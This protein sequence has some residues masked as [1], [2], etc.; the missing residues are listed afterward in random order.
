MSKVVLSLIQEFDLNSFR[1]FENVWIAITL[2]QVLYVLKHL[3]IIKRYYAAA[4]YDST[5]MNIVMA[6]VYIIVMGE[7]GGTISR[8]LVGKPAPFIF[9]DFRLWCGLGVW[10][11]CSYILFRSKG[12]KESFSSWFAHP[13]LKYVLTLPNEFRRACALC[14]STLF[15]LKL[16]RSENHSSTIF[17]PAL[18]G[19]LS[20]VGG[21]LIM[22]VIEAHLVLKKADYGI[23]TFLANPSWRLKMPFVCSV[24]YALSYYYLESVVGDEGAKSTVLYLIAY[25]SVYIIM[26]VFVTFPLILDAADA[27]SAWWSTPS[28]KPVAKPASPSTTEPKQKK[29][30]KDAKQTESGKKSKK[31]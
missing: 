24:F 8:I 14:A 27:V 10:S 25:N 15:F 7:G 3:L 22:N 29:E 16:A 11:V 17:F 20:A 4:G 18:L 1:L 28:K 23:S 5:K 2:F 19:Y 6:M 30:K 31:D 26:V 21:S 12:A 9:N 13:I